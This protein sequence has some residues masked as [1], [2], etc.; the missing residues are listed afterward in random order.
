MDMLHCRLSLPL[1]ASIGRMSFVAVIFE[2]P[3]LY[4]R[5]CPFRGGQHGK[6]TTFTHVFASGSG[7]NVPLTVCNA[8]GW[9]YA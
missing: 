7:I 6:S 5:P 2:L 4:R 9:K 3:K 8:P 1:Q